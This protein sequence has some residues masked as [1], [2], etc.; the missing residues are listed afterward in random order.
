MERRYQTLKRKSVSSVAQSC[1]TLFN[2][3]DPPCPSP[4]PRIYSDSC[5]LSRWC[6]PSHPLSSPSPPAFNLSQHQGLF[7]EKVGRY[8]RRCKRWREQW[9]RIPHI[10]SSEHCGVLPRLSPSGP[11]HPFPRCG[12]CWWLTTHSSAS[13]QELFLVNR[14]ILPKLPSEGNGPICSGDSLHLQ[15]DWYRNIKS[16]PSCLILE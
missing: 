2:P 14:V 16:L 11:E 15:T 7:K 12:K 13:L 9:W 10:T 8:K 1:P 4:P 5:P 3:M 6:Q